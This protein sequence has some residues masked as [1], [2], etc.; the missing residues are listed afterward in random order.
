MLLRMS[1]DT[2]NIIFIG[3]LSE[4]NIMIYETNIVNN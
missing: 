2:G 3:C 1:P 4:N